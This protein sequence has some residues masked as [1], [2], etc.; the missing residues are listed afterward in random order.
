MATAVVAMMMC[1]ASLGN[2]NEAACGQRYHG[3]KKWQIT[4][5]ESATDVCIMTQKTTLRRSSGGNHQNIEPSSTSFHVTLDPGS[6]FDRAH[7]PTG[8]INKV[9]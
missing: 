7:V 2:E 3:I 1:T 4:T 5:F 8:I 6:I 9:P